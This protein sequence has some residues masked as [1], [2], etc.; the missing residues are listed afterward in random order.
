MEKVKLNQNPPQEPSD[1]VE[2]KTPD[3]SHSERPK[4]WD[5][6]NSVP[7]SREKFDLPRRSRLRTVASKL[8]EVSA[9]SNLKSASPSLGDNWSIDDSRLQTH[10]D[11]VKRTLKILKESDSARWEIAKKDAHEKSHLLKY[12]LNSLEPSRRAKIIEKV[13]TALNAS[14]PD[15]A[16]V[17][18]TVSALICD[19]M[20]IPKQYRPKIMVYDTSP[21][22]RQS[23]VTGEKISSG[24]QG[25]HTLHSVVEG[26]PI[27]G[28]VEIF[29]SNFSRPLRASDIIHTLAHETF[30]AYQDIINNGP[31]DYPPNPVWFDVKRSFAY[32][33]GDKKY[34]PSDC[35]YEAYANQSL[36]RS[37]ETYADAV[38][39]LLDDFLAEAFSSRSSKPSLERHNSLGIGSKIP[40]F[41]Q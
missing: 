18:K 16:S 30:H 38:S 12:E 21:R 29:P 25:S 26:S 9:K 41:L 19:S 33:I 23:V 15:Y 28:V 17:C 40:A 8:S 11:E 22:P 14:K 36:E 32:R 3:S 27:G 31:D 2:P 7:F 35:D 5:S 4:S 1:S 20:E 13:A 6:L 34:I 10:A 24:V 39:P 37:A